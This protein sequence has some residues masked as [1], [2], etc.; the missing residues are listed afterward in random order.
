ME[1]R[2]AYNSDFD[3]YKADLDLINALAESRQNIEPPKNPFDFATPPQLIE[4]I[5]S[6]HPSGAKE[7]HRDAS[8]YLDAVI[9]PL[10][11]LRDC[12]SLRFDAHRLGELIS[13]PALSQLVESNKETLPISMV[14]KISALITQCDINQSN[15]VLPEHDKEEFLLVIGMM[16]GVIRK[17]ILPSSP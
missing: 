17:N 3:P 5:M 4:L 6:L 2:P 14:D 12:E 8:V 10:C 9:P 16:G 1:N 11:Y 15:Q 13:K 7:N